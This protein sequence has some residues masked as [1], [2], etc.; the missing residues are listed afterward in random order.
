[1]RREL[2]NCGSVLDLGC[3]FNSPVKRC[4][5][6][7]SVGVDLFDSYLR[8]SSD[9]R[10]HSQYVKA[11]IRKVE[12]Q[13]KAFDAVIILE[14]LEH[15]TK[16]D[17]QKLLEKAETWACKKIIISTP[18]GYLS[19]NGYHSNPLQKHIS[20]WT[21]KELEEL[22]FKVYGMKGWKK[23]RGYKGEIVNKPAFLWERFSD[24]TQKITCRYPGK[25][26]Q[27][28]AVKNVMKKNKDS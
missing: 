5:V 11:D 27:L 22:D 17:G 3:G 20:G 1:M 7:F 21:T 10:H 15:L 26:F 6:P 4:G 18:N 13:P 16:D 28:F 9:K 25:A 24:I 12:F 19:Q 14:V 8:E 2:L 23:L